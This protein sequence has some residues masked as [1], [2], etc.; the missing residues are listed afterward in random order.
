MVLDFHR[1]ASSAQKSKLTLVE[2]LLHDY[3]KL[4]QEF[5]GREQVL[6]ALRRLKHETGV[7]TAGEH[8][9]T[10]EAGIIGRTG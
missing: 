1:C 2:M 8:Q 6:G 3:R 9:G 7:G 10:A 4:C 5:M